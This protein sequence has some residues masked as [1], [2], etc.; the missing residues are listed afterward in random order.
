MSYAIR[1]SPFRQCLISLTTI[2]SFFLL[3][4][5]FLR[6]QE[7][8]VY[9]D[10][11][12]LDLAFEDRS[13]WVDLSEKLIW[14]SNAGVES[15]FQ[16]G[17]VSDSRGLTYQA[18][19]LTDNAMAHAGY[20]EGTL[21]AS[22]AIDVRFP[23]PLIRD[24]DTL[25]IEFDAF[26][27]ALN[28]SGWGESGRIVLTLLHD[29]PQAEIPFGALDDLSLEHP[30][31]RPAYNLRLRNIDLTGPYHS[32]A[33]MLYGGGHDPLGEI[34]QTDTY[35][36]PGF[37]S[38]A[39]GGTPGLGDP[40]PAS[41]TQKNES[42]PVASTTHWRHYTWVI[43]PERLSF[44]QR[45]ALAPASEN[46]R[47]LWMELPPTEKGEI[48]LMEQINEAHGASI[49]QPPPLYHWFERL[50]ALRVYFRAV[51]QTYLANLQLRHVY[52]AQPTSR[53]FPAPAPSLT[54]FP[55]PTDRRL[56]LRWDG[57][58]PMGQGWLRIR[59]LHDEQV[60]EQRIRLQRPFT[61]CTLPALPPGC[62]LLEV[63]TPSG[64]AHQKL[65]ILPR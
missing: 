33:F 42:M 6:A 17:P 19:H 27:A 14:G 26:W 4:L 49:D 24:T 43:A 9:E 52:P 50:E 1:S 38:E 46:E 20:R 29:Y 62:Y 7:P 55:N 21:R 8:R 16:L 15:G 32:G 65:Y 23:A 30:F 45:D 58:Q 13:A 28:N 3:P 56:H 51:Q 44:F 2:A 12:V 47:V 53:A 34:E 10:S 40:Y 59:T 48:A 35:W 57:Q 63:Q 5:C 36:L 11:L 64:H 61:P 39:G 54:V 41:P 25:I 60:H 18:L 37:S 31:G 22:Q